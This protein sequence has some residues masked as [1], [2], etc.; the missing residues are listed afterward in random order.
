[1]AETLGYRRWKWKKTIYFRW[2]C[3]NC[4]DC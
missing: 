3:Q 1:M 4:W 2:S